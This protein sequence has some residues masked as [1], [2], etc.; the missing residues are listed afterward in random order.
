MYHSTDNDGRGRLFE[1]IRE[2]PRAASADRS[3]AAG[4]VPRG[5]TIGAS[6]SLDAPPFRPA[7]RSPMPLPHADDVASLFRYTRWAHD[8]VLDALQAADEAPARAVALFGHLLRAQDVWY[9]RVQGTEHADL[10]LWAE[11]TLPACAERL[12]A[13]TRRWETILR[14]RVPDDLDQGIAYTNSKGTPFE[15]PLRDIFY[16]VVNHGT[17]HRAQIALLLREADTA[18]PATDYIYYLREQ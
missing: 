8:R 6:P 4:P 11:T 7:R 16:H 5:T 17:H 18:P 10:D 2:K 13:S 14:E 15:T 1:Y 12:G 9:G 3:A